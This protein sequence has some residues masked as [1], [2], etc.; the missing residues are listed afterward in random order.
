[1]DGRYA[2]PTVDAGM[3]ETIAVDAGMNETIAWLGDLKMP[4]ESGLDG[5]EDTPHIAS[6][7][8]RHLEMKMRP[9]YN[10]DRNAKKGRK[11]KRFAIT[12]GQKLITTMF[13]KGNNGKNDSD[14]D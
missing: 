8:R 14:K 2:I 1:M 10:T 7:E 11:A 4:E 6:I 12:P 5:P 9:R 3:N 13:G